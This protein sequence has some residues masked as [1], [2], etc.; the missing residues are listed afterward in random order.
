MATGN[1]PW[2]IGHLP[3]SPAHLSTS[4]AH[5]PTSELLFFPNS[6]KYGLID[7]TGRKKPCNRI[8]CSRFNLAQPLFAFWC[9]N[10]PAR[11]PVLVFPTAAQSWH[12]D[13]IASMASISSGADR[14]NYDRDEVSEQGLTLIDFDN[15]H[16][17]SFVT[18]PSI[19]YN[20][21]SSSIIFNHLGPLQS[22]WVIFYHLEVIALF[23]RDFVPVN[24]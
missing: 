12:I 8:Y 16:S 4:P 14:E 10:W 18:F 19:F 6:T 9:N 15:S 23:T 11:G 13:T 24:K 7:W 5:R 20:L 17:V 2:L 21:G 1:P 3:T 22:S